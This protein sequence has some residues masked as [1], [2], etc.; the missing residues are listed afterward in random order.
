MRQHSEREYRVYILKIEQ[1]LDHD[2]GRL[3]AWETQLFRS[4][5]QS[6]RSKG[7]APSVKQKAAA[8]SIL[9]RLGR[10]DQ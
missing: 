10:W 2:L 1:A 4:L 5:I 9:K 8:Y 6:N 3:T 7:P